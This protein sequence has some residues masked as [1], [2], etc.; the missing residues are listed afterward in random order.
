MS[1]WGAHTPRM[2][3]ITNPALEGAPLEELAPAAASLLDPQHPEAWFNL[4][5]ALA[6][7]KRYR[8]AL[9]AARR[10]VA[11]RPASGAYCVRLGS[12]VFDLV[13]KEAGT[14]QMREGARMLD[15]AGYPTRFDRMWRWIAARL[16]GDAEAVARLEGVLFPAETVH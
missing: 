6:A 12:L 4:A 14:A 9:A 13:G 8:E 5:N 10:A 15:D 16:L 2:D 7:Q 11:L 3:I 1:G